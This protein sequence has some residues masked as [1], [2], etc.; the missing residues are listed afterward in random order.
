MPFSWKFFVLELRIP[1]LQAGSRP[2]FKKKSDAILDRSGRVS[3]GIFEQ[4]AQGTGN[5][6]DRGIVQPA[7][8]VE[9]DVS[10]RLGGFTGRPAATR[11]SRF[12]PKS[13]RYFSACCSA[14]GPNSG[15]S[16]HSPCKALMDSSSQVKKNASPMSVPINS[17]PKSQPNIEA[18]SPS[19]TN[20]MTAAQN[21]ML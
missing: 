7:E 20:T 6:D 9:G 16:N 4:T 8:A 14:K 18:K 3:R 21:K 17:Q 2:I 5:F 15:N 13:M 12:R 19:S 10:K 11:L 1:A